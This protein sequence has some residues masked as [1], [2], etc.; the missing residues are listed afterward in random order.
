MDVLLLAAGRG[1]R[2]APITDHL[3]KCLVPIGGRPLIDHWLTNILNF[4]ATERVFINVSYLAEMV[5]SHI[6]ASPFRERVTLLREAHL[7]GTGGTVVNLIHEHGPFQGDLLIVH[8]DN[9][10]RFS[11]PKF[12]QRHESRRRSCLATVLT[13]LTDTP[14]SCGILELDQDGIVQAFHE[15]VVNP[16]GRLAS[17]AVF[18]FSPEALQLVQSFGR[19]DFSKLTPDGLFDLSRD[20]LTSLCGRLFT[21]NEVEYHRDIGTPAALLQA[22]KDLEIP[23]ID[24]K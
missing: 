4:N 2:L 23:L 22:Q 15:K 11:L 24:S 21:F 3:P 10:S 7:L 14:E 13:F 20:F 19:R 8:A 16:P 6:L 17:G 1:T 12:L 18:L 5:T 9:V